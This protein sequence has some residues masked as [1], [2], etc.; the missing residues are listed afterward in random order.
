MEMKRSHVAALAA[1]ALL[2]ATSV[3]VHSQGERFQKVSPNPALRSLLKQIPAREIGRFNLSR[4]FT[5]FTDNGNQMFAAGRGTVAIIGE[6]GTVERTF[7]TRVNRPAIAPHGQKQLVIGD[8]D[9]RILIGLSVET[10]ATTELLKLSDVRD[11]SQGQLLP[12]VHMLQ[13]GNFSSVASDGKNLYI[14]VEAGFSSCIFKVDPASKNIVGR[15]WATAPDPEAMTFHDG[16][17]FV[18][19]GNGTQVRRFTDGLVKSHDHIDL[20]GTFGKGIG[21]RT[22]EI[23]LLQ[24]GAKVSRLRVSPGT[25]ALS[26]LRLNLDRVALTPAKFVAIK[27]PPLN[28]SK[29]YAVL[30]CGDLAENFWGECFW[31]DTVWMYKTLLANGYTKEDIIVLYGDGADFIS[32]NPYYQHR[33]GGAFQ[34]VTDFAATTGNVNMVFDGLK[35]GDAAKGIPKMDGND[36]LFLW[37]FDHGG[38]SG[39]EATLVLRNG[40]IKATPFAS[41][42]NAIPYAQRAIFMQQCYS[43]GFI[44]PLKN[45]RTYISTAC[46]AD[47]VARPADDRDKNGNVIVENEMFGGKTYS[48]GEYNYYVTTALN[49]LRPL[50]PGGAINADSNAD[51]FVASLEMHDWNKNRESRQETPQS[52]DLGGIGALFKFKK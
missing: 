43:G 29:R 10:G 9:N 30:I 6:K 41:K 12:A 23:R 37:T 28:F 17:L 51:T 46:K 7:G 14:G 31:N 33:V 38:L 13:D 47:E 19:V 4:T 50:P 2:T 32:A 27:F 11:P 52:A 1:C 8:L 35:N 26:Q 49:R 45:N 21:V 25:L 5:A 15:A 34:K 36:T 40:S 42:L 18:L 39:G 22:G 24:G 20:P 3:L 48:H 44:E 16:A